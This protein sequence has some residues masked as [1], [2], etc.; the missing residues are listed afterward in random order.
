MEVT[1]DGSIGLQLADGINNKTHRGFVYVQSIN[2]G[3]I[4][5]TKG[6]IEED[7]ILLKV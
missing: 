4:A 3:A 2:K 5:S 1:K 6:E 7:D